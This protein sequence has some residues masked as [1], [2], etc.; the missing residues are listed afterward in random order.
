VQI[1][2]L[3]ILALF[4]ISCASSG[5]KLRAKYALTPDSIVLD[6]PFISQTE[7]YCG[8]T[9]LAMVANH[10]DIKTTPDDVAK[11]LYTSGLKGTLQNDLLA[12]TRRLGLIALPVTK[13]ELL[14]KEVANGNPI[15]VF[16]N[17][18]LKLWPKW[19]YSVVVG[20]DLKHDEIILHSGL[21]KNFALK[22]DTFLKIWERVDNWGLVIVRPGTIAAT[23]TEDE[24]VNATA[25]LEQA[26]K[27]REAIISYNKIL[28]KWPKSLGASVGLGNIYYQLQNF[29]KSEIN[30]SNAV[31]NHPRAAGAWY[32]YS[33]V[34]KANKKIKSAQ[35][36][37]RMAIE[38]SDINTKEFFKKS[39]K[40]ILE[41]Q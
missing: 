12:T 16:Q 9:S 18:G 22:I 32:N 6:V 7:N 37:A 36:A 34:L 28:E 19:H 25:G 17:L 13:I 35:H 38:N 23:A 41:G 3:I 1:A 26:N 5:D 21:Q 39:L 10:L 14:L 24:I 27:L 4:M 31:N 8:P 40:D 15:L 29:K 11:L 2:P 20:Y 30:L 33:L